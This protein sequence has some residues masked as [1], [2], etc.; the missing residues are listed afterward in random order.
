[1][2]RLPAGEDLTYAAAKRY[3][4]G[5][6]REEAFAVVGQLH[7]QGLATSID[8]FGEQ[9]RDETAARVAA[10]D[11]VALAGALVDLAAG[12]YLSID[13][14][15]VGLDLSVDLCRQQVERI[16]ATM[17]S[18][19]RLQIGAEDSAR[20]DRILEVLVALAR[21][22][23]PI[24]ATLQ[25]NLRRSER[26]ASTVIEV[27]I[28]VR[29]VKGAYVEP[30]QVAHRWGEETDL[31]Y[32]RLAHRLHAAGTDVIIATHDPVLREALLAAL[33]SLGVEM[34]LGVR[35][36]DAIR[37]AQRGD[38]VRIYVPY[39]QDW[40]R[41]WMRRVAE[42][43]CLKSSQKEVGSMPRTDN[44]YALPP[45]LPIPVDDG[46]CDRLPGMPVPS[47][48]LRSTAGDVLDLS[49]LSGENGRVLLSTNRQTGPGIARGVE[50]DPLGAGM[51][52]AVVCLAR[53][54]PRAPG[55]GGARVRTEHLGHGV[56]T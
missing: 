53:P 15:H 16:L 10:D 37:L 34:L 31:A 32:I 17:P 25:A 24:M 40:F 13:L 4:A 47:I 42:A 54:S 36:E 19:A 28:P 49:L 12:T 43:R 27:G 6:T 44:L 18:N 23:G 21:N 1:M 5:S 9:V 56:S 52:A 26:D 14:S 38:P 2:R 35:S 3:V 7:D 29:L 51:Y 41:Y 33:P 48:F 50:P 20:T 11:Y 45:D 8:L 22:G 30:P 39:G 46:A 55:A